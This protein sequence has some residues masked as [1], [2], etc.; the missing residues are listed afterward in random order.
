M[1]SD[2]RLESAI[3]GSAAGNVRSANVNGVGSVFMTPQNDLLGK[4]AGVVVSKTPPM[5]I[6]VDF[7]GVIINCNSNAADALGY[8]VDDLI[9]S[10]FLDLVGDDGQE[11]CFSQM[12]DTMETGLPSAIH[13][14]CWVSDDEVRPFVIDSSC[15]EDGDGVLLVLEQ[16]ISAKKAPNDDAK[17]QPS[18]TN[19]WGVKLNRRR[20]S[21]NS[22]KEEDVNLT[23]MTAAAGYEWHKFRTSKVDL[24]TQ[25]MGGALGGDIDVDA[26]SDPM[27]RMLYY[28]RD[29]NTKETF[30][31]KDLAKWLL[32]TPTDERPPCLRPLNPWAT[33]RIQLT[34][35]QM[36]GA[37]DGVESAEVTEEEFVAWWTKNVKEVEDMQVGGST[38]ISAAP[39]V[40][41]EMVSIVDQS[42]AKGKSMSLSSSS[43]SSSEEEVSTSAEEATAV[44][45]Q[46][47]SRESP[48]NP[49]SHT[50]IDFAPASPRT[51]VAGGDASALGHV[52]IQ[53]EA[54]PAS[55]AVDIAFVAASPP[56]IPHIGAAV[57]VAPEVQVEVKHAPSV[58]VETVAFPAEVELQVMNVTAPAPAV[59]V[60][61]VTVVTQS[62][63]NAK[64]ASSSSSSEEQEE[65]EEA[66]VPVQSH[67]HLEMQAIPVIGSM[68]ESTEAPTE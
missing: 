49:T 37:L 26:P 27:H 68:T 4:V 47:F 64:S 25:Q 22:K 35:K 53:V 11:G 5:G 39:S 12:I 60:E 61:V 41:V 62:A 20:R 66:L 48:S 13:C 46:R 43:S 9:G 45:I 3:K 17:E 28:L 52:G 31:I 50:D 24:K 10:Y 51:S 59:A 65:E 16:L 42:A 6:L 40:A 21:R 29:K 57:P 14:D 58:V 44:L 32:R 33:K 63:E 55:M 30:D 15:S 56:S 34:M 23:G 36:D 8:S 54:H 1:L 18:A 19:P 38:S 2:G 67:Y 7:E